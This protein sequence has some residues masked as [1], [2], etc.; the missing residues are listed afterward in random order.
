[1]GKNYVLILLG[2]FLLA[3]GLRIGTALSDRGVGCGQYEILQ[4]MTIDKTLPEGNEC[5][6]CFQNK[7]FHIVVFLCYVLFG[8]HEQLSQI[9]MAQIICAIAGIATV[10]Y[11]WFFLDVLPFGKKS[12]IFALALIAL[13][14]SLIYVNETLCNDAAAIFS[15]TNSLFILGVIITA[16]IVKGLV[17]AKTN[18]LKNRSLLWGK[19]FIVA[20]I[21]AVFFQLFVGHKHQSDMMYSVIHDRPESPPLFDTKGPHFQYKP[22]TSIANSFFTFRFIDLIWHPYMPPH[23]NAVQIGNFQNLSPRGKD[24]Y[25]GLMKNGYIVN[26]NKSQTTVRAE[27]FKEMKQWLQKEYPDDFKQVWPI[28]QQNDGSITSPVIIWPWFQTSVWTIIYGRTH[29]NF[30]GQQMGGVYNWPVE[31]WVYQVVRI[32]LIL[33]LFPTLLLLW[34]FI[35]HIYHWPTAWRTH[36]WAFITQESSWIFEITLLSALLFMDSL[37]YLTL[38]GCSMDSRYIYPALLAVGYFLCKEMDSFYGAFK[39]K[40]LTLL[41]DMALVSLLL[42]YVFSSVYLMYQYSTHFYYGDFDNVVHVI[43]G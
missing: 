24:I 20:L 32:S 26:T 38:T 36:Q 19:I 30:I 34:G 31:P 10:A 18:P 23:F 15:K 3:S 40:T 22:I 8:I 27:R 16:F 1:M 14:P 35:K 12:K 17:I 6:D 41:S 11:L 13:N 25:F 7:L 4:R 37:V 21:S 42:L 2:V 43:K 33:A 39:N 28:L 9:I 5:K 29:S